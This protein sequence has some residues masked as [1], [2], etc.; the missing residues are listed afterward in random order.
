MAEESSWQRVKEI[1]NGAL[2]LD[3]PQQAAFLER[4]CAG[5]EGL[6]KEV[7]GLLERDGKSEPF[8][9]RPVFEAAAGLLSHE[10]TTEAVGHRIGSYRIL[11][12]LGRGGMG[13][14]YLAERADGQYRQQVAIKKVRDGLES[15][16]DPLRFQQE[17]QILA[18]LEHPNIARL[19]DGGVTEEGHHPYLVMEYVEG[20]PLDVHCDQHRLSLGARL[21]LFRQ[22]CAAVHHAHR[23][24]VVHCDLKP[25]NILVTADGEPKLLDFGVA[26]LLGSGHGPQPATK[27]PSGAQRMTPAFASPEQV[28]GEPVTTASDVY[29]L[30]VLLY[31]LLTGRQ[32]YGLRGRSRQELE[33]IICEQ[34][35]LPPSEVLKEA[36]LAQ[37]RGS[38]L[39]GLRRRLRGDLDAIT[40]MALHKD[41]G[42]RY[43]SVEQLAQDL[44][45]HQVSL[46]VLARRKTLAYRMSKFVRRHR[47]G[48]AAAALIVLSL[49]TGIT[50]ATWQARQAQAARHRAEQEQRRAEEVS[51]FLE[52]L[53]R[54]ADP[55]LTPNPDLTLR[56]FLDDAARQVPTELATQPEI[57]GRLLDTLG[58]GYRRLGLYEQSREILERALE[59]R[60]KTFG[61]DHPAVAESL[62]S[63][64]LAFMDLDRLEKAEGLVR[65]ALGIERRT[66]GEEHL[67]VAESLNSLGLILR[68]KG[69]VATAGPLFRE[70][71][72][73]RRKFLG[74]P[75]REVSVSLN[76]LGLSLQE[77]GQPDQARPLLEEALAQQLQ[78]YGEGHWLVA[79]SRHNLSLVLADL[80]ELNLAEEQSRK[81]LG[82]YRKLLGDDH[83]RV[84]AAL[85]NL[86]EL[87]SRTGDFKA[88]EAYYHQAIAINEARRGGVA[89]AT[90][91]S[92]LAIVLF[93]EGRFKEAEAALI[94]CLDLR[95]E[96]LGAGHVDFA[97]AL[98]T[99]AVVLRSAGA[100]TRAESYLREALDAWSE[101]PPARNWDIPYTQ[102]L[103]GEALAAAGKQQ[104]ARGW[105]DRGRAGLVAAGREDLAED[106]DRHTR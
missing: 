88:S 72:A 66:F 34:A 36:A 28:R 29:S 91:L 21:D 9:D 49:L 106:L 53:F 62:D 82:I 92:Q 59:V 97:G 15:T 14:V 101:T 75:Q 44:R 26:K 56:S 79:H 77:S 60:R 102:G 35:P 2:D 7:E 95:R 103:L 10:A 70:S 104:E 11:R 96:G 90:N 83:P 61:Q 74:E 13:T 23:H 52:D 22:V 40:G 27:E 4:A 12:E 68:R 67:A 5:D 47:L 78:L 57:Q 48:A 55:G 100:L 37:A 51:A 54:A 25:S 45:N 65:Q 16:Q 80:G 85:H 69:E 43:S 105:I 42:G 1:F 93:K 71:L 73:Q 81:A 31:I 99:L 38:T 64:G 86:A 8:L 98:Y 84:A 58:Q 20:E 24:L 32:P 94:R 17:R 76:N 87:L 46:P 89:L 6:R 50:A 19:L 18:S 39:E 30:G 41:P 33:R 3:A 63:L